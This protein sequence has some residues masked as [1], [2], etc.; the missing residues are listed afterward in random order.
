[1]CPRSCP[2][3]GAG[4]YAENGLVGYQTRR[5]NRSA[6]RGPVEVARAEARAI[7]ELT[8]DRLLRL[9]VVGDARTNAAAR[10]LAEAVSRYCRRGM[11]PR[12][13]KK[14]WTYTHGWRTVD[15]ASWG[16]DVSVLASV[17]TARDARVAMARGYAAALVV[18]AFER[19]SAY[20]VDGVTVLPC[21]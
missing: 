9:H 12:H 2:W 19:E 7:D 6:V 13:G 4:C 3:F 8:G 11:V 1:S 16:P 18:F 15:R 5:L 10:C 20:R 14:A 17:E 21:P